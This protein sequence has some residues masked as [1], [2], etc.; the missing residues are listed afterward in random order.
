MDFISTFEDPKGLELLGVLEF[1]VSFDAFCVVFVGGMSLHEW[2][3]FDGN[4]YKQSDWWLAWRMEFWLAV[5][6][7]M[8]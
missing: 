7:L 3:L 1:L 5:W 4:H 8:A 6:C 2:T